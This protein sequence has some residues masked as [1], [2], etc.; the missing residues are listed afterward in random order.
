MVT[1][2]AASGDHK[3]RHSEQLTTG[4]GAQVLLNGCLKNVVNKSDGGRAGRRPA[5]GPFK[6][7]TNDPFKGMD[8]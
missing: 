1:W 5:P 3:A 4:V 2:D 7:D 8:V 6:R